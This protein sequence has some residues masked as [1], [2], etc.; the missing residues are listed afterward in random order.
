MLQCGAAM[1]M[2]RFYNVAAEVHH[3]QRMSISACTVTGRPPVPSHLP[4]TVCA[5]HWQAPQAPP[6]AAFKCATR[7]SKQ[8]PRG[9]GQARPH[10][11]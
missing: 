9:A 11:G 8:G 2:K 3:A 4:A 10:A 6:G 7:A 1:L 5:M